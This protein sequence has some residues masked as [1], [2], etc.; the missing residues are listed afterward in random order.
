MWPGPWCGP[1][2][3]ARLDYGVY[4][5]E[6]G[7]ATKGRKLE[8]TDMTREKHFDILAIPSEQQ[9]RAAA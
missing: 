7:P 2:Y 9:S 3:F 1:K 6:Y 4:R 8:R 5:Y